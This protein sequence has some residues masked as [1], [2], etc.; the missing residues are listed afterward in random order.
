VLADM[1]ICSCGALFPL[2][3]C[4]SAVEEVIP[5]SCGIAIENINKKLR[6]SICVLNIY[7]DMKHACP[8]SLVSTEVLTYYE[9]IFMRLI[10]KNF[11]SDFVRGK[12]LWELLS[13]I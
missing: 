4:L 7:I 6:M 2:T 5:S 13:E 12:I 8:D 9:H 1:Q 3:S 11:Q 10:L